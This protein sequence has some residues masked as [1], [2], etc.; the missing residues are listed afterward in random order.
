MAIETPPRETSTQPPAPRVT[1]PSARQRPHARRLPHVHLPSRPRL[2][3]TTPASVAAPNIAL[4]GLELLVGYEWLVSGVDKLLIGTFPGTLGQLLA[5]ALGGGQLP[6][7]FAAI[8]RGL[9]A[10]NAMLFGYLIEWSETLAGAGLIAAALAELGRPWIERHPAKRWSAPLAL[11]LRLLDV[12][13]PIAALGAGLLGLS[14][15]FLDGLPAPWL[16]PSI[17]Y[18]GAIDTGLFLAV[19]SAIIVISRLAGRRAGR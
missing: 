1:R 4:L 9:V 11:S 7:F 17:A 19:A 12:L 5:Q 15:F 6:G 8:L 2:S 18:G 14:F 16:A 3:A 13:A 10:S